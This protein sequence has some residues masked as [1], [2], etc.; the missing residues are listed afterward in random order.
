MGEEALLVIPPKAWVWVLQ[1]KPAAL[2]ETIVLLD[3]VFTVAV[4]EHT[5]ELA[6]SPINNFSEPWP[7]L[8]SA[9]HIATEHTRILRGS[10]TYALH[11]PE[12]ARQM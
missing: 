7:A 3:N 8:V 12:T 4:A 2:Q 11:G 5:F 9:A 10:P 1:N 6:S